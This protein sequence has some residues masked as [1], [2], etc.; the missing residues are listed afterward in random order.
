[1]TDVPLAWL[2][3]P[4]D[5]PERFARALRSGA[6]VVIV[7]LED[8]V[9]PDH[10]AMAREAVASLL[11][12]PSPVPVEVRINDLDS[13]WGADDLA[14]LAGVPALQRLRIPKVRGAADVKR[15]LDTLPRDRPVAVT[16][17]IESAVGVEAAFEI[18]GTPSVMAIALGEADLRSDLG[19]TD[20]RGLAYARGR[21][22]NAAR[23]AG[24][25]SP[26]MSPWMDVRDLDGLATSCRDG[27]AT[28]FLGR[29]AIHPNQLLAIVEA[30]TP[31]VA[32]V[33]AAQALVDSL[34]VAGSR[35]SGG[36]VLADGRFADRAMVGLAERTLGLAR[37]GRPRGLA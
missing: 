9:H 12:E 18:A 5:R 14:E 28:G 21:I 10:K 8:A 22:I 19:V 35:S 13:P 1:M 6:D 15:V 31:S 17:L 4:G 24:L 25:P 29:A 34:G 32:E 30:F 20:E 16:A 33:A 7:D 2:Y 37:R 26:A 11:A 3:V 23:A 27:R 36:L